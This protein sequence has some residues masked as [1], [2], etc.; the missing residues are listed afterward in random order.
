[1]SKV[2]GFETKRFRVQL[3]IE[4]EHGYQYDG[5]DEDGETQAK[6]DNG[7]YV[8]FYSMVTVEM[9]VQG[10]WRQIGSESLGGSVYAFDQVSE[11][12]TAHR[13]PDPANRNTLALKARNTVICHYFPSMVSEAIAE[14]RRHL[15]DVA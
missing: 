1:M 9:R 12:W 13:D 11:F 4:H 6:L 14:A 3:T 5:D 2:W 15:G 8:A 10:R 7:E